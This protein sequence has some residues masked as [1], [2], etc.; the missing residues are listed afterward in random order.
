MTSLPS[1]PERRIT[2]PHAAGEPHRT[3][4]PL[5]ATIAP[6][7][8]SLALW[9]LTHSLFALLFAV[10]GP[11]VAGASV[12]DSLLNGRRAMRR[13]RQRF[14]RE[15]EL[16][17]K[18]IEAVHGQERREL[19][20][21]APSAADVLASRDHAPELWR[22]S[23]DAPL[24]LRLGEGTAP[25]SL[26]LAG[27]GP[28][29]AALENAVLAE[30][31][32]SAARLPEASVLVDARLG[33]GIIGPPALVT[34]AARGF[35]IQLAAALS[36]LHTVVEL[37]GDST[38][39]GWLGLLPHGAAAGA[40]QL[41]SSVIRF[42][43][44]SP[45]PA[46]SHAEAVPRSADAVIAVAP[47]I[48]ALPRSARVV[49][50]VGGFG[51]EVLRNPS[52]GGFGGSL[53]VEY[54]SLQQALDWGGGLAQRAAAEGLVPQGD[55]LPLAVALG[56]LL[57]EAGPEAAGL[58]CV[59]GM[60]QG[61]PVRIDL[62]TD[63]PH[64]VIGGTTGSGKS[65]LLISWVLGMAVSRSPS[66]L[67]F[68]FVDFKGGASFEALRALPHCAG[69][70][71]DLDAHQALRALTSL[72][73]ETRRRERALA[74]A[75]ARSIDEPSAGALFPRL[76]ILV[77]EY[78]AMVDEYPDLQALFT[79]LAARGRSLGI[80]LV[81]CTQR[82]AGVVRDGIL[83]N[84]GLRLSL[85]V[86]NRADSSAVIGSTAAAS[87]PVQPLGRAIIGAG[88]DVQQ[89]QVAL[90]TASDVATVAARWS[91][92][93]RPRRPWCSPLPSVIHRSQLPE[94]EGDGTIQDTGFPAGLPFALVDLPAEQRQTIGRYDPSRLGNLVVIGASGSGK[95]GVLDALAAADAPYPVLRL[96]GELALLWDTLSD[97]LQGGTRGLLLI[98][99][100]DACIGSCP[101]EYLGPL[102][103]L[104][105]RVLREGPG[106]GLCV[107]FTVQRMSGR[108]SSLAALCG[109]ALLMRMPNRQEHLLAGGEAE[110]W[111]PGLPPGAGT[112]RGSR[113]QVVAPE[114]AGRSTIGALAPAAVL[115]DLA[116]G[117]PLAIVSTRPAA[118]VEQLRRLR[119]SRPVIDI[120]GR[121]GD[122]RQL[123][124]TAGAE[125]GVLIGD[126]DSW[127]GAWGAIGALRGS[128]ALLFDGCSVSEF[129]A[130]SGVRQL[131]P[132]PLSGE[133][134]LWLLESSGRLS[135]AR[136]SSTGQT[137]T[138]DRVG[139]ATP[140]DVPRR[141]RHRSVAV[142]N[143]SFET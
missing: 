13:E 121:S 19:A 123:L 37:S 95:S 132:P 7:V 35:V 107:V 113:L 112:W 126:P 53:R 71:T 20:Q 46:E 60:G 117:L 103:D 91:A 131:P 92:A 9:A 99:D 51:A 122:P 114:P 101:E 8:V 79:D 139:E 17:R 40:S 100:L 115:L 32:E 73:A 140:T 83:A 44:S 62:A 84:C 50:S 14:D 138:E 127:H 39:W 29:E 93:P 69:I 68:L 135:R 18:A 94:Q 78:A 12:G 97:C 116:D 45:V 108:L 75:G 41:S 11:V 65:E 96:S 98:D 102:L 76:V 125:P 43:P 119:P 77:D 21:L 1:D 52:L 137:A 26:R 88:G 6:V 105:G 55:R 67:S 27:D 2:L 86:N 74:D 120:A 47:T 87:L 136:L 104:L 85:R 3:A 133:R 110:Q 22:G 109:S 129:R 4:F 16:V 72:R 128:T 64:A 25:S 66:V 33:V 36:P 70:I 130:L 5:L 81:L 134:P 34:A 58:D 49:L 54:V 42:L 118:F 90:A 38:E 23:L 48:E 141:P 111:D 124:V 31:R 30:L 82:P 143:Q 61:G 57:A 10:L 56:P 80:H 24:R 106:R 142:K 15:C 63:G 28:A 59:I 89:V